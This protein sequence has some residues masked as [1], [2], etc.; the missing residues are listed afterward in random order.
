[1]SIAMQESDA[2]LQFKQWLDDRLRGRVAQ[3]EGVRE[4]PPRLD[5]L[6]QPD[7]FSAA[8]GFEAT[9]DV[10]QRIGAACAS[11]LDGSRGHFRRPQS[12]ACWRLST[13]IKQS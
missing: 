13:T 1:M 5:A 10:S 9:G 2:E 4:L 7:L 3:A 6:G 8:E 12:A 11:D